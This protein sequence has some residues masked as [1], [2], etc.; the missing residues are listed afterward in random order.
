[1][2]A[3]PLAEVS[4]S[5]RITQDSQIGERGAGALQISPRADGHKPLDAHMLQSV[6][7]REHLE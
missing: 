5:I 1:M 6:T 3:M 4:N 2:S 7:E